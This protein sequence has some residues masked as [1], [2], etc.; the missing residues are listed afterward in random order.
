M[1]E[2]KEAQNEEGVIRRTHIGGQAL[3]EGIMMR[4]RYN[5]AVAVR[6]PDGT[7]YTEEHD[8]ASGK[9]KNS[10]MYKPIIRGC[11]A[12][13]ESLALGYKALEISANHAYDFDEE[14]GLTEADDAEKPGLAASSYNGGEADIAARSAS[15][16][17]QIDV[18]A[19]M[20][21]TLNE[22]PGTAVAATEDKDAEEG[23]DAISGAM[24]T[25]AM[26]MG[27]ILGIVIF[28]VAPAVL[29]NLIVGDYGKETLIWNIVDGILRVAIFI[30]YIW[31]IS[32]MKDIR[33][34]FAYHGAEHKTIHCYERGLELTPQNAMQFPRLHVRCGTAF[35]IMTMII[36]ILVFT[37][38]PINPIIEAMGV[39]NGIAK[40]GLVILSRIILLPLI[41]GISYEI[42]VKWAGMHPDNPLVKAVLW[43]GMQMQRL[44]TNPPDEGM[45][46]CAIVATQLVLA[47][48]EREATAGAAASASGSAAAPAA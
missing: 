16:T 10:W 1:G 35:L 11:T 45:L 28:I 5:W 23:G 46:E 33:R 14:D 40:L 25:G 38:V 15:V 34:L 27:I 4:G 6:Q 17:A 48:E 37:I 31:L 3:I 24:M 13:V 32:L 44:T 30:I 26:V 19:P 22:V 21:A 18:A 20:A 47:R 29:T 42:T 43:P 2:I 41:A 7:I 36:A 9:D 12:M 8:L 39:T